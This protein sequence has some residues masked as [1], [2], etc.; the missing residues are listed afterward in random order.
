MCYTSEASRTSFLVNFITCSIL[1]IHAKNNN[2]SRIFALFFAFVGL[3]QLYDWIFWENL[4]ENNINYVF[5]KIA[6]IS[7]HLQPLILAY[8]IYIFTGNIG[9]FSKI[10]IMLYF[11]FGLIYSIKIYDSIKYTVVSEKSTPSLFWEWNFLP[12]SLIVYILFL[13]ALTVLCYENFDYP[14]NIIFS[15][16]NILSFL[17]AS[18]YYKGQGI[19]RFWCYFASYIP[20]FVLV[21]QEFF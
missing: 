4:G 9:Y 11:I 7:N 19:G 15:L 20:L 12:H 2:Y 5:T 1:Y 21:L 13:L 17:F 10:I 14:I 16:I 6:M 8:L 3:M 18:Y